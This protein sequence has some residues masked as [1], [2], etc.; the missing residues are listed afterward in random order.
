M[1][2]SVHP[3]Q[4][5]QLTSFDRF[6][7]AA[8]TGSSSTN[9]TKKSTAAAGPPNLQRGQMSDARSAIKSIAVSQSSPTAAASPSIIAKIGFAEAKYDWTLAGIVIENIY[10]FFN[11]HRMQY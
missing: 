4:P 2:S 7:N 10:S 11:M 6:L 3:Q 9:A 5:Q 8:V 1:T